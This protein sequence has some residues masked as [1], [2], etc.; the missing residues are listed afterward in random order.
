MLAFD[1]DSDQTVVDAPDAALT[2]RIA[3]ILDAAVPH[4]WIGRQLFGLFRRAGLADVR[5]V[6]HAICL[7]GTGGFGM[8]RRLNE[9]TI[10]AAMNAGRLTAA[11]AAGWWQALEDSARTETFF[12][13]ILGF[14]VVGCKP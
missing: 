4:P 13:A 7:T 12:V 3:E 6:P 14:I 11:D 2:R 10:A 9:G 1:F 8:S 5:V